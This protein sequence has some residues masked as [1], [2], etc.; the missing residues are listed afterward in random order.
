MIK[1]EKIFLRHIMESIENIEDFTKDVST[2]EFQD[3]A[4][5]QNG[6]IRCLEIIGEA[7]KN[8]PD[9]MKKRY[10]EVPWKKIAG[11]RDVLIHAY[12]EVDLDLTWSIAKRD[13]PELKKNIKKIL[14][15]LQKETDKE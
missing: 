4:L 12:F 11:L 15:E 14:E 7:V 9:D 13:L 1:D 10:P 2:T 5:I 8:I 6:V 3:S